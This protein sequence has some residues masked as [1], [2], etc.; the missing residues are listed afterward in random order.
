MGADVG[1]MWIAWHASQLLDTRSKCWTQQLLRL[2]CCSEPARYK[3]N[4]HKH[5]HT[6]TYTHTTSS[7]THT[8][9]YTHRHTHTH[10]HTHTNIYKHTHTY[11][12]FYNKL[13]INTS[14]THIHTLT[15]PLFAFLSS[16]GR[17]LEGQHRDAGKCVQA[18]QR[19]WRG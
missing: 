12:H 8:Y 5:I 19:I 13:N 9:T 1:K 18:V 3:L 6:H 17:V 10:T 7:H 16:L 2:T 14:N 4:T 11:T 15:P